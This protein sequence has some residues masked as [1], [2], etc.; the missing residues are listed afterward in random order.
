LWYIC[1]HFC[2]TI[3]MLWACFNET[4]NLIV[5]WP[6]YKCNQREWIRAITKIT[7]MELEKTFFYVPNDIQKFEGR[8]AML[9]CFNYVSCCAIYDYNTL[10]R[11]EYRNMKILPLFSQNNYEP[12]ND[13]K[14]DCML[15][16]FI[17]R[18]REI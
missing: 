2:H 11:S 17:D 5:F 4:K 3:A 1:V 12:L 16:S 6:R 7:F 15:I 8:Y 10:R 14:I 18:I 13:Y 9:F